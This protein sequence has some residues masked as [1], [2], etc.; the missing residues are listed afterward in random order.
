MNNIIFKTALLRGE[1]GGISSIAK[2]ST[3]GLVDTYTITYTDGTTSTFQVNN[4]NGISSITKTATAGEVDTYTI[5]Y[6]NGTTSTFTVTNANTVGLDEQLADIFNVYGA[7]NLLPYPYYRESGYT[8]NGM[9]YTVASDGVITANGTAT[10]T[11]YLTL[12]NQSHAEFLE[13]NTTYIASV[14][15]TNSVRT[16]FFIS[17]D[18]T[19]VG[20]IRAQ[21]DGYYEF[22]FT[23]PST[24]SSYSVS[25][26]HSSGYSESGCIIKPMIRCA[27]I[28]DDTYIPFVPTNKQLTTNLKG[29]IGDLTNV[30]GAKNLLPYPYYNTTKTLNGVT[31]TD[32]GD[33]SITLNGTSTGTTDF[34]FTNPSTFI[35]SAGDYILSKGVY[36]T[37]FSIQGNYNTSG[38]YTATFLNTTAQSASFSI[39][40]ENLD[41]GYSTHFYIRVFSGRT[42]DN[43]TVYT[44]IRTSYIQDDTYQPYVLTN[45]QLTEEVDSLQTADETLQTLVR[46]LYYTAGDS[47]SN[48]SSATSATPTMGAFLTN[49]SHDIYCS[50]PVG[51]PMKGVS[52]FSITSLYVYIRTSEGIARAKLTSASGT[53]ELSALTLITGGS[54]VYES[55]YFTY[56]TRIDAGV[57]R[58]Y[59]KFVQG[60]VDGD[61]ATITTQTP[62]SVE[63]SIVGAFT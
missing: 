44:M 17:F 48:T 6:T 19:D 40:Q 62:I 35:M 60:L 30:Y 28:D 3:S 50:I 12:A 52:G 4:G 55:T 57:I 26:Y 39:T 25:V 37:D 59:L 21:S 45:K 29:A 36:N 7:K 63:A 43:V 31:F 49:S 16:S 27:S 20:A 14:E 10:A 61:G 2:T 33:G 9:T 47:F 54:A 23:T 13:P 46:S 15:L 5:N 34:Y 8:T 1:T 38:A 42:F 41:L 18:N 58:L 24:W 53:T 32:N 22:E 11:A 56:N 51:K